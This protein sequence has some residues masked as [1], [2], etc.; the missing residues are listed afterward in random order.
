MRLFDFQNCDLHK[1]VLIELLIFSFIDTLFKGLTEP[2]PTN[3]KT[4]YLV[5]SGLTFNFPFPILLRPE[6]KVDLYLAFDF[7]SREADN[8]APFKV[9]LSFQ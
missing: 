1:N 3:S 9:I 8:S 6:R 4:I 2:A 7:S 5:D